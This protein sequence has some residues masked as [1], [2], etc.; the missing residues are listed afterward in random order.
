MAEDFDVRRLRLRPGDSLVV[1][2]PTASFLGRDRGGPSRAQM[3][4]GSFRS[5]LDQ[6]G[7]ARV[8]VLLVSEEVDLAVLD[9]GTLANFG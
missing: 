6:A 2:V 7:H 4:A 8:P 3:I 9:G 1:R 5:T